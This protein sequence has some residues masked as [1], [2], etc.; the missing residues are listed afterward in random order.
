MD[1]EIRQNGNVC[2]LKVNGA[3]RHGDCVNHFEKSIQSA[4]NAGCSN[5]IINLES[6]SAIDSRGIGSI[7]NA[8]LSAKKMGGDAKLV[9]PSPFAMKTMKLS[10]IYGLFS[11]YPS[12][13][14]AVAACS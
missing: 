9:N 11:V 2:V 7:V 14:D 6:M 12:E 13:A 1:L 5:L 3:L 8:L 10:A 4:L